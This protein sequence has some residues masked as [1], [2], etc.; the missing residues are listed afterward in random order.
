MVLLP[1]YVHPKASEWG[2]SV[3]ITSDLEWDN[4]SLGRLKIFGKKL[5]VDEAWTRG[6]E[7]LG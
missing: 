4:A 1:L 2:Q 7:P 6:D 5:D 3:P